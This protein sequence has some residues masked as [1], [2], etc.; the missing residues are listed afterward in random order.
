MLSI[1]FI[2]LID[3]DSFILRVIKYLCEKV[4][5]VNIREEFKA[6][7]LKVKNEKR[8]INTF[9]IWGAVQF[10][11]LLIVKVFIF[12]GLLKGD[13]SETANDTISYVI[14]G[15]TLWMFFYLSFSK[16]LNIIYQYAGE[17][18]NTNL[19]LSRIIFRGYLSIYVDAV[20]IIILFNLFMIFFGCYDPKYSFYYLI[21]IFTYP[22]YLYFFYTLGVICCLLIAR[23][24]NIHHTVLTFLRVLFFLT[25]VIWHPGES[26]LLNNVVLYNPLTYFIDVYRMSYGS[27]SILLEAKNHVYYFGVLV[28][29]SFVSRA[30]VD[31]IEQTKSKTI[32]YYI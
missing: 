6:S 12:S 23:H 21:I 7:V 22:V 18:K 10:S 19:P 1:D 2:V 8:G 32:P 30:L 17:I 28:A 31:Q 5:I 24:Q 15:Y 16:G 26:A 20:P 27:I 9:W 25:P 3:G 29:L 4:F 13:G 14:V 11:I